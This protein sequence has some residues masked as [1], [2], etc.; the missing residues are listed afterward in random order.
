MNP[1]SADVKSLVGFFESLLEEES[2]DEEE[3]V[4]NVYEV[5]WG[6]RINAFWPDASLIQLILGTL[7]FA[8]SANWA[9]FVFD[10]GGGFDD[11]NCEPEQYKP[12]VGLGL[13]RPYVFAN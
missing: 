1:G 9:L 7:W 11:S 13:V 6:S 10:G 4:Y 8:N 3:E 12:M 5:C 2:F